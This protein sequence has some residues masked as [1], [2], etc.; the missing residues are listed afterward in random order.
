MSAVEEPL[1]G[2]SFRLPEVLAYPHPLKPGHSM[3]K[4]GATLKSWIVRP[5]VSLSSVDR[6]SAQVTI[7]RDGQKTEI[8]WR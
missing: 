1:E 7:D 6:L 8:K 4:G 2:I 5:T 3:G